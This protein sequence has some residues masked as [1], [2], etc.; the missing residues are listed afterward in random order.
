[1]TNILFTSV[2]GKFTYDTITGLKSI[3]KNIRVIGVDSNPNVE[4]SFFDYFER[5]PRA[6]LIRKKYIN[7]ILSIVKKY[8]VKIVIVNSENESLAV[9]YYKNLFEKK[10]ILTSVGDFK[11]VSLMTD[12]FEM[13]NFLNMHNLDTGK[14]K[15][16]SNLAEA[17]LEVFRFGYPKKKVIL[18][19]RY[20][21]GSRGIF[22]INSNI[23]KCK[24]LLTDRICL[25]GNWNIIKDQIKLKL[26]SLD[27]FL[28]MPFYD[29]DTFDVDCVAN[30]G[31]LVNISIRR[32]IYEN[33]FSPVN[34]GCELVEN[35][36][37]SKYCENI[38]KILNIHKACDFDITL[39]N[40]KKP[41][42]LDASSRLSGSVGASIVGGKNILKDLLSVIQSKK[43]K[44]QKTNNK[45]GLRILPVAKFIKI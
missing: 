29:G 11:T 32:R 3:D 41:K 10:N 18:K 35:L 1:M 20:G 2:G 24:E 40:K 45:K 6:D 38:V 9:S 22:V 30:R 17:E 39:D 37:I 8:K 23:N 33:P 14:F 13:M 25:E 4:K 12:K 28:L 15:K 19:Q 43:I 31:K 36:K 34:E 16:I 5:V 7:K 42:I 44:M 27:N 21:S 26:G